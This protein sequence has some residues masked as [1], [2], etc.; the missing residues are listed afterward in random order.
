M[1]LGLAGVSCVAAL[2]ATPNGKKPQKRER[3]AEIHEKGPAEK[4]ARTDS[5]KSSASA[6]SV[7]TGTSVTFVSPVSEEPTPST[8]QFFPEPPTNGGGPTKSAGEETVVPEGPLVHFLGGK[9]FVYPENG[10][11]NECIG[12]LRTWLATEKHIEVLLVVLTFENV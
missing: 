2:Q 10:R 8:T 3:S 1:L 5:A 12:D 6:A 11:G 7:T 4:K 9:T